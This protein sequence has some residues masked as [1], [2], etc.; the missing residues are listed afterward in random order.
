MSLHNSQR[1]QSILEILIAVAV[2]AVLL[3]SLLSLGTTSV[4]TSTYSRDLN[5]ATKFSNQVADWLRNQRTEIGWVS[6]TEILINHG[7]EFTLC[8]NDFPNNI[9]EFGLIVPG[10]CNYAGGE[11]ISGTSFWREAHF[12]LTTVND[13]TI[14][15]T[16]HTHWIGAKEY[17]AEIETIIG[18]WN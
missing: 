3:V 6:F 2:T 17:K 4:K 16:I 11:L 12:N 8:L 15:A 10:N 9:S 7:N 1:G 14:K 5:L 13:G 18:Q